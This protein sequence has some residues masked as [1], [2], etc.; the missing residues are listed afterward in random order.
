MIDWD[1]NK[2]LTLVLL[3]KIRRIKKN[4]SVVIKHDQKH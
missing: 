2:S 3:N 1:L 4:V